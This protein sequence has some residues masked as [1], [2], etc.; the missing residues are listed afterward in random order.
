M[1]RITPHVLTAWLVQLLCIT[2]PP[3]SLTQ[4]MW[5]L[6]FQL[7][8]IKSSTYHSF[9]EV[10]L[11]REITANVLGAREPF[12]LPHSPPALVQARPNSG[13]TTFRGHRVLWFCLQ[14]NNLQRV[15][16]KFMV[17]LLS[18]VCFQIHFVAA[19]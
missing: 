19:P 8:S 15:V 13:K 5:Q 3:F 4:S 16:E 11:T 14:F 18:N 17:Q 7:A 2:C 1:P 6:H 10:I 12:A 9:S